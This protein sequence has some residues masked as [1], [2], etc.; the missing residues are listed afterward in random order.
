MPGLKTT[1]TYMDNVLEAMDRNY[2]AP[3]SHVT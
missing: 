3:H 2:R 1:V